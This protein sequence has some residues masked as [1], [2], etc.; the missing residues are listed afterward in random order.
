M[1]CYCTSLLTAPKLPALQIPV[2]AYASMFRH[3]HSL[4]QPPKLPATQLNNYCYNQ[5]FSN[6]TSLESIP[7]VPAL[8]LPE[9]CYLNMFYMCEQLKVSDIQTEECPY[10]YRV[11]YEGTGIV[12]EYSYDAPTKYMFDMGYG[13]HVYPDPVVNTTKKRFKNL[14]FLISIKYKRERNYCY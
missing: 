13:N 12:E 1:F 7:K 8:S 5:M 11:P 6:C 4:R 2:S 10:A 9:G 14:F 3:C